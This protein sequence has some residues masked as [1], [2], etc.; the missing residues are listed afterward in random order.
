MSL[1]T[2]LGMIMCCCCCWCIIISDFE[3]FTQK[4]VLYENE[5]ISD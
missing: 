5:R 4:G 1:G 2:C 3:V